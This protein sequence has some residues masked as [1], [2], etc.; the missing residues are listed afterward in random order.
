[1]IALWSTPARGSYVTWNLNIK[2]ILSGA[3]VP[4]CRTA[5]LGGGRCE[6]QGVE[7]R[8][9]CVKGKTSNFEAGRAQGAAR[10]SGSSW[11]IHDAVLILTLEK[12]A[13]SL[14]QKLG[15]E[16]K[17]QRGKLKGRG[18]NIRH[19]H[20]IKLT[21]CLRLQVL[22]KHMNTHFKPYPKLSIPIYAHAELYAIIGKYYIIIFKNSSSVLMQRLLVRK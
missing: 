7:W 1:M 14:C 12:I 2:Q 20:S 17:N 10:S 16:A 6:G 8:Q 3:G 18:E 13:F 5:I 21:A 22:S 15:N 11:I 19:Q 4:A 9:E